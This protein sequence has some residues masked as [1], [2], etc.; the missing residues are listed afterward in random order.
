[1]SPKLG[2][3]WIAA[4]FYAS[5]D[6]GSLTVTVKDPGQA[7][8]VDAAV[9]VA[10]ADNVQQKQAT[11]NNGR[12]SFEQLTAGSYRVAVTK[13]GFA[14]WEGTAKV[15][16]IPVNLAV[17]LKLAV[18]SSSVRVTARRSPLANSDPN[19]QALR[20]GK[21][22]KVYRFRTGGESRCRDVHVSVGIV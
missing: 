11:D 22:S 16:D 17:A 21:L 10:A 3:A 19:Y 1:M 4:L 13:E 12:A 8:V 2:G 9:E 6:A 18:V 20:T 7:L 15:A 14:N 5:L